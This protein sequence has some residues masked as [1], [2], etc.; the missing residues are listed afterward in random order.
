ME[1]HARIL[2]QVKGLLEKTFLLKLVVWKKLINE[3]ACRICKHHALTVFF[4][5]FDFD[6]LKRDL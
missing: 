4:S 1:E 6:F 2:S 3:D 5:L